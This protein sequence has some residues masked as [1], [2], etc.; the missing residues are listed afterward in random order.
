MIVILSKIAWVLLAP[1]SLIVIGLI[2][3]LALWR[4]KRT[5]RWGRRLVVVAAAALIGLSILPIGPWLLRS[6]EQRF[7]PYQSCAAGGP[8]IA[9]VLLLGGG[10]SSF[11][12]NGHVVEDLNSAAD[13]LRYA[14][15]LARDNPSLPVLISGGQVFTRPG[16]RSEADG[17]ADVLVELGVD[18]ARLRLESGSRTTAQN[19]ELTAQQAKAIPGRWLLVTSAFHMPRAMGLFRKAGVDV[20]AAPTDWMVDDAK[21]PLLASA[22]GNIG[23]LE[24]AARE[25]V[26]TAFAWGTGKSADLF[27]TPKGPACS[28]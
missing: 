19:A 8:P 23:M 20:I 21:P 4:W 25:Y 11:T 6:L 18:R 28:R 9:G 7:P 15:Q 27:P 24:M 16:A 26:G 14:A 3:G 10:V 1:L 12:I 5:A 13:R 17:M 22:S 2:A